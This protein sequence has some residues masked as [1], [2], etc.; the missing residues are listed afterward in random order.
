MPATHVAIDR[1][2]SNRPEGQPRRMPVTRLKMTSAQTFSRCRGGGGV[3]RPLVASQTHTSITA[4]GNC[5]GVRPPL[6]QRSKVTTLFVVCQR[7]VANCRL[8]PLA[9]AGGHV[10]SR[11]IPA[12]GFPP[13]PR[14]AFRRAR[15]KPS[16]L[17]A[18]RSW[19]ILGIKLGALSS[20]F[21]TCFPTLKGLNVKTAEVSRQRGPTSEKLHGPKAGDEK[22]DSIGGNEVI[23][24][25]NTTP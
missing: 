18:G 13:A 17:G 20:R 15:E 14:P 4:P 12:R 24:A 16:Q 7:S 21:S 23:L 5:A 11:H 10:G 2:T 3:I 19:A 1:A 6:A 9:A 8:L 22:G 25:H